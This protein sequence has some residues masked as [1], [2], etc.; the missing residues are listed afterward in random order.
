MSSSGTIA[1]LEDHSSVGDGFKFNH[2]GT[3]ILRLGNGS[4]TTATF[5]GDVTISKSTP[6]L[7]FNNLA[8]GGLDPSLTATGTDFT[9]STS[10]I[11][12]LTIALDTGNA[13]VA[14]SLS[15][16]ISADSDSTYTGIVV[17]ESGTLK[18]LSLIHI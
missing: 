3:E 12:P 2:L 5:A 14:G 11:T 13:T 18:Y 8:G 4:S 10:S 7:T 15:A 6:V 16:S 17:S 9:I 1:V